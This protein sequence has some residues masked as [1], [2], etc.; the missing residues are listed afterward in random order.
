LY[1][2]LKRR[3]ASLEMAGRNGFLSGGK[4][5]IEKE[6]LRVTRD[7]NIAQ[8][9]HPRALGSALTHPYITT[10]YSEALLELIT[11]PLTDAGAA[12]DYLC[13]IHGFVYNSLEHELLWATSMPCLIAGESSIPIADYGTSNV[14]TMKHIYRRGLE[15]RYGRSMQAI[16]GVHFNYSLPQGFWPVYQEAEGDDRAAQDFISDSYFCLI[17]NFHRLGWII[18]YLFGASPAVCKSFFGGSKVD[19]S[20]FD[21]S[22]Y[23]GPFATSLR[24]SDIGYTNVVQQQLDISYNNIEEYVA[25]LTRAIE[26]PYP[27]YEK[28]GVIADGEYIQLNTNILQIENEYYSFVRPKQI[29]RSGEKPTVALKNRGVQYVEIRALDVNLFDPV[30]ISEDQMRFM[31]TFLIFCM[32]HDSPTVH[33]NEREDIG[34]NQQ[35]VACCGRDPDIR[36]RR[37]G[38]NLK[39]TDWSKEIQREMLPIA[40]L[41][42]HEEDGAPYVSAVSAALEVIS[43]PD[44]TPSARL[45]DLMRERKQT[46]YHTAMDMCEQ[47]NAYFKEVDIPPEQLRFFEEEAKKSLQ[48]QKEIEESDDLSFEEYLEHYFSQS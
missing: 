43:D 48:H 42:D 13:R 3:L 47:H 39:V 44:R 26:T 5:G 9:P 34:R 35:A 2:N 33:K 19:L 17:R 14:G 36:L 38:D 20:E 22:T 31:E 7:G 41:L 37:N 23:Y 32:L 45:L 16:A 25:G 27:E 30:G 29:A 18:P 12:H 24:M 1:K 46:F 8:T 15:Y 11:P 21:R 40:E 4:I 10:D 6:S 28:I